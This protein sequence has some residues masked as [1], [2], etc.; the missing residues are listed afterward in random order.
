MLPGGNGPGQ[1]RWREV[2]NAAVVLDGASSF[3]P[4]LVDA[5]NYVDNLL[6]HITQSLRKDYT[7]L[8]NVLSSSIRRSA[9]DL[10]LPAR[11]R[12]SSTVLI[13]QVDANSLK[14][15]TLGD[16]TAIV[17]MKDGQIH[18]ITDD[19]LSTVGT[20]HRKEYRSRLISGSGY[21]ET[22]KRI[23]RALQE[24]ELKR[25]NRPDGYWIAEYAPEAAAEAVQCSFPLT[26]VEWFVLTTDGAQRPIDHLGIEWSRVAYMSTPELEDLLGRLHHWEETE[27]QTASLLP[28]AK[29]HD[30]K[31][32]VVWR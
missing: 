31:T 2:G 16:S 15:L 26:E 28:R 7:S 20:E 18:R 24:E 21:D 29:L 10:E 6:I 13:A 30:D 5:Q 9:E 11:G 8:V 27:D 22:H 17:C 25:R 12:P 4:A 14:V 1:D 3:T 32:I 23:L 19:R